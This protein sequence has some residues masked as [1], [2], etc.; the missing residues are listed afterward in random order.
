M[1]FYSLIYYASTTVC[2]ISSR[3]P[4]ICASIA[5]MC[6]VLQFSVPINVTIK[7]SLFN[8]TTWKEKTAFF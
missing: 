8:C 3:C 6:P 1:F 5:S 4:S 2:L 7:G